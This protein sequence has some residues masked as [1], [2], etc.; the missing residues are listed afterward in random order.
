[1]IALA[2]TMTTD[3]GLIFGIALIAVG[4]IIQAGLTRW[5]EADDEPVAPSTPTIPQQRGSSR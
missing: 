1:M 5:S 4:M 3:Q 2:I